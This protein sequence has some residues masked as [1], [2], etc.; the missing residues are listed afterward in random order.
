[1][2]ATLVSP[3][4]GRS[5]HSSGSTG[6]P[7]LLTQRW[8]RVWIPGPH[9]DPPEGRQEVQAVK[10]VVKVQQVELPTHGR[11]SDR[12]GHTDLPGSGALNTSRLRDCR[13]FQEH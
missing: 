6:L 3:G 13:D 2:Q 7:S 10:W 11:L 4:A 1:M 12:G 5:E 8:P 9:W